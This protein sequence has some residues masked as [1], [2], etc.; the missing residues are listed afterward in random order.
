MEIRASGTNV[1]KNKFLQ[2][3]PFATQQ[4]LKGSATHADLQAND[5]APAFPDE[6]CG[7][8]DVLLEL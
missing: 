4:L 1:D 8:L 5:L 6:V 2:V 7:F 3:W